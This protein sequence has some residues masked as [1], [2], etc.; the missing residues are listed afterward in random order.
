MRKSVLTGILACTLIFVSQANKAEAIEIATEKTNEAS[1]SIVDIESMN[2]TSKS[3]LLLMTEEKETVV[4]LPEKK[5]PILHIVTENETLSTIAKHYETTWERI[6]SKNVQIEDPNIVNPGAQLTIPDSDEVLEPRPAPVVIAKPAVI[7]KSVAK[8]SATASVSTASRGS[9]TGNGYVAGYCTWYVKNRRPDMPNN[10]GNA[11]TWVSRAAAQGM[12]TGATP[13]VGAV[14]QRGNHVV[15]V[16][17]ING[18]GTVTISEM[19]HKGRYVHTTRTVPA[20]YF[21]YIY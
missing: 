12:A 10:L 21:S 3:P 15:Y 18:D 19:N 6:Y 11:S 4:A 7:T 14:G 20:N 8:K 9:S 2:E 17:S 16:E 5:T 13:S 1:T